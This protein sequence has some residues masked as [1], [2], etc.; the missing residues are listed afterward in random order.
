MVLNVTP[1]LMLHEG[2]KFV[3][4]MVQNERVRDETWNRRFRGHYGSDPV[5]YSKLFEDLQTTAV[6]EALIRDD[7]ISL[8]Y[9]LM[10]IYF[11]R[12]YPTEQIL[13]SRFNAS[14]KTIRTWVWYY[15]AKIKELKKQ[16]V[17]SKVVLQHFYKS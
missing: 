8:H 14:E 13:E 3:G 4:Y 17:R 10:T 15:I 12:H 9:F 1:H 16:K 7:K 6:P 11:L 5:V 2:L